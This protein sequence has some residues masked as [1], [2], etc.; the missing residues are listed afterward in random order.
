MLIIYY[1]YILRCVKI[2]MKINNISL[3]VYWLGLSA[4][5]ALGTSSIPG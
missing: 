4:S 1:Y 5:T 3:L 2:I